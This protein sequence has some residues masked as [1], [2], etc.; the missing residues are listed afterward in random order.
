MLLK[1]GF[2]KTRKRRVSNSFSN[3]CRIE[4]AISKILSRFVLVTYEKIFDAYENDETDN[5]DKLFA[6]PINR[7]NL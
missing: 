2:S 4:N 6:P 7:A 3:Q 5:C 1:H